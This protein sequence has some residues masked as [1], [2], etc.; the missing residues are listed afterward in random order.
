MMTLYQ[1]FTLLYKCVEFLCFIIM[2]LH[3]QVMSF[4]D[5]EGITLI[6][7]DCMYRKCHAPPPQLS[8]YSKLCK[9]AQL[10]C[11]VGMPRYWGVHYRRFYTLALHFCWI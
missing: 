1:I 2:S 6:N 4:A 10:D 11:R 3:T 8:T 7:A 5:L 9:Q